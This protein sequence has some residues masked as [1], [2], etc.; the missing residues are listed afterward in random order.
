[1][2]SEYILTSNLFKPADLDSNQRLIMFNLM[3]ES[4]DE[5]TFEMFISDLEKKTFVLLIFCVQEI[6]GFTTYALDPPEMNCQDYHILF[7]GDTI[8]A[9]EHWGSQ[10]MLRGGFYHAGRMAAGRPDKPWYWFLISKG[11]RT[12]M[13]MALFFHYY[14][15][16]EVFQEEGIALKNKLDDCASRY[17]GENWKSDQGLII[18]DESHGALKKPLADATFSKSFK[19]Q[20][21]FF[22]EKNPGFYKG[23]ELAC[24]AA[25]NPNN[26]KSYC[27][28]FFSEGIKD[29][30][31][32]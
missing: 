6:V 11:H 10:E 4:Y 17:F 26:M 27:K 19:S 24:F 28:R 15:P 31:Q 8:I 3:C 1:M 21:H 20:V 12:Y 9:P 25:L 13:Y 18:F 32:W 7:S 30:I 29:P 16:N 2:K 23:D 14:I 22:L 5:V